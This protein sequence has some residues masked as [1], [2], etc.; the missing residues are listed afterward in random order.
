MVTHST[1][2][3]LEVFFFQLVKLVFP[4]VVFV[5]PLVVLVC[6]LIVLVCPLVVLVVVLSVGLFI[7]DQFFQNKGRKTTLCLLFPFIFTFC[8]RHW[9]QKNWS[10]ME[11]NSAGKS[12]TIEK[13]LKINFQNFHISWKASKDIS[14]TFLGSLHKETLSWNTYFMKYSKRN[15]LQCILALITTHE[16]V[17]VGTVTPSTQPLF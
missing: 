16:H 10:S 8:R 2:L 5:C 13:I 4:L 6:P 1:L 15:I 14:W 3:P 12:F 17:T 11:T 7:T 9:S